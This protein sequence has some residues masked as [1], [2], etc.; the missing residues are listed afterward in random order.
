MI[1]VFSRTTAEHPDHEYDEDD[2]KN[3][4][5]ILSVVV[6]YFSENGGFSLGLE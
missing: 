6:D 2:C 3:H 4:F 1:V 5:D